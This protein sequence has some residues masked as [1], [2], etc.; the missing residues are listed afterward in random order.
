MI[1]KTHIASYAQLHNPEQ[2]IL[3]LLL[4]MCLLEISH[5]ILISVADVIFLMWEDMVL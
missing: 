4:P 2:N 1:P 3:I 5:G